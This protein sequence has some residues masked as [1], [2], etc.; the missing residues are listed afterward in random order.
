MEGEKRKLIKNSNGIT[1]VALITAVIILLILLGLSTSAV[2][3]QDAI[4]K[5]EKVVEKVNEQSKTDQN[6][7][8]SIINSFSNRTGETIKSPTKDNIE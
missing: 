8:N 4:S 1:L 5:A 3:K 6:I 2:L 7:E